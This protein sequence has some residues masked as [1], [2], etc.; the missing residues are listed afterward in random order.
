MLV[1]YMINRKANKF[2]VIIYES[3]NYTATRIVIYLQHLGPLCPSSFINN[4]WK[5]TETWDKKLLLFMCY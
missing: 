2:V 1:L 4:Y 3:E 5:E